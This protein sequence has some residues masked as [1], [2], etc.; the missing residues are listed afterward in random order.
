ML[1]AALAEASARFA[2]RGDDVRYL[3][4]TY[5]PDQERLLSLFWAGNVEL[6]RAANDASLVP[7]VTIQ[8]AFD[9]PRSGETAE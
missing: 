2:A 1:E 4:S 6:V 8:R 9:L 7:Y 3:R 5:L